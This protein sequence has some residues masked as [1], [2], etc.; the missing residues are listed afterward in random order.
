M[1][2]LS[3]CVL[4]D[5]RPV[6]RSPVNQLGSTRFDFA[7][8]RCVNGRL[9]LVGC[10]ICEGSFRRSKGTTGK[11]VGLVETIEQLIAPFTKLQFRCSQCN[12]IG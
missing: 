11:E 5:H 9:V 4:C 8:Q 12:P 2:A 7:F 10:E 3:F 1:D 6:I